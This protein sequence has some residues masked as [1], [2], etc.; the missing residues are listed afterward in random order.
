MT[1]MDIVTNPRE[2]KL[3]Q[4]AKNK[5]CHVVYGYRMLLWQ[6]VYKFKMYTNVEPPI[7]VMAQAMEKVK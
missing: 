7:E 3:L 1:V 4:D 6:G 5:G 2:T